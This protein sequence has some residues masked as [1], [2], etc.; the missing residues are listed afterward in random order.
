MQEI[1]VGSVKKHCER[2]ERKKEKKFINE[3]LAFVQ[4]ASWKSFRFQPN[5]LI[6]DFTKNNT[7]K[8]ENSF[9][10]AW[11]ETKFYV[12]VQLDFDTGWML[13][14][15]HFSFCCSFWIDFNT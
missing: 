15:A 2:A 7:K 10:L 4:F 5:G 14:F 8:V 12:F 13:C 9:L 1:F 6:F 11:D 3:I